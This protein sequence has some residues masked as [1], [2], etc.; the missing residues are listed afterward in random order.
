MS[1]DGQDKPDEMQ[2]ASGKT[3]EKEPSP[4]EDMSDPAK[5]P[6]WRSGQ[7]NWCKTCKSGY[8]RDHECPQRVCAGCKEV[9]HWRN[10]CPKEKCRKCA[11]Y[12]HQSCQ[13]V[14]GDLHLGIYADCSGRCFGP[15]SHRRIELDCVMEDG[16]RQ[17]TENGRCCSVVQRQGR[18]VAHME[19]EQQRHD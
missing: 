16:T 8:H 11:K 18:S 9:G 14:P 17:W 3:R 2:V 13:S 12:G 6:P 15:P 10:D 5:R 7:R 4:W 1:T 19:E